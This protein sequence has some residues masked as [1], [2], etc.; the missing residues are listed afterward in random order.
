[1]AGRLHPHGIS[2]M[3]EASQQVLEKND[4]VEPVI[5]LFNIWYKRN[6]ESMRYIIVNQYV[7][8]L[9]GGKVLKAL[10]YK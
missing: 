4:S 5:F 7:A 9:I 8:F 3:E 1:M 10:L 2:L 6:V